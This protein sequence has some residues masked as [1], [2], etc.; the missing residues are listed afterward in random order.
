MAA[1]EGV[2]YLLFAC[3]LV[4]FFGLTAAAANQAGRP[5]W[6]FNKGSEK[7]AI[8][9]MLFRLSFAGAAIWPL[10]NGLGF[11]LVN[12]DPIHSMLDGI[13]FDIIGH[14]LVA[15]GAM[16]AIVS[17]MHMGASWRIGAAEGETG[18]IVDDGPFAISRN[19]VFVGQMVMFAG[20]FLVFPGIVQA[21]LTAALF[22]AVH[23]QVRIEERV[24]TAAL[25]E[26]Y[27]AYARRVPRWFAVPRGA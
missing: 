6:L 25:G 20:L 3:Y 14:L 18:A 13:W 1:L 9:A 16:V 12:N 15:I 26:P 4:S 24:L 11:P 21:V 2:S 8:P 7:Q 22:V 17:H 10:L 23:L 19:P 27:V 5:V